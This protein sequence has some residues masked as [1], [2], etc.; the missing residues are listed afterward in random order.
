MPHRGIDGR[1]PDAAAI[2]Q[3]QVEI[4]NRGP[5]L[6]DACHGALNLMRHAP[7]GG[8]SH[9]D[10]GDLDPG[11]IPHPVH[12]VEH[13]HVLF[14]SRFTNPVR[15]PHVADGH[16]AFGHALRYSLLDGLRPHRHLLR[17][18]A[19]GIALRKHIAHID[20]CPQLTHLGAERRGVLLRTLVTSV[21]QSGIGIFH[22]GFRCEALHEFVHLGHLRRVFRADKRTDVD[23]AQPRF[24]QRI[25]QTNL[26]SDGNI[27][28]L[29]LQTVT[30]TFFGMK[31]LGKSGHGGLLE[32]N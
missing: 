10:L 20:A 6:L 32:V 12:F 25:E 1:Q 14:K 8:I 26:C 23:L 16:A 11:F 18:R 19:I 24:G 7:A 15:A 13:Q 31:Y 30:H 27:G 29:Y 28:I 3:M 4:F 21:I 2:V 5:A 9:A 22:A 17:L